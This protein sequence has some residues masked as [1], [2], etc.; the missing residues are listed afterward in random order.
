MGLRCSDWLNARLYYRYDQQTRRFVE[1][2]PKNARPVSQD[3][4]EKSSFVTAYVSGIIDSYTWLDPML[5]QMADI[6]GM[7]PN[8]K[9]TLPDFLDRVGE[10]CRGSLQKDLQDADVLD[11]VSLHNQAMMMLRAKLVQEL[12]QKFMDAGRQGA[13]RP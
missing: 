9:I 4:D 11:I 10:L 1:V 12:L 8:A 6:P 3:T 13:T 7:K 5:Q 2:K